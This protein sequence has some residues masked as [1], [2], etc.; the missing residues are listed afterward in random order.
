[1]H[2]FSGGCVDVHAKLYKTKNAMVIT[3]R[4]QAGYDNADKENDD[5]GQLSNEKSEA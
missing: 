3:V 1:M 4:L 2:T 5:D